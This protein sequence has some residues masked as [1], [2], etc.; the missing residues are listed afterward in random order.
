MKK[1][2]RALKK[3][4]EASELIEQ[5]AWLIGSKSDPSFM[6]GVFIGSRQLAT[7]LLGIDSDLELTGMLRP[8][9]KHEPVEELH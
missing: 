3:V 1:L 7:G 9:N 6:Y 2:A 5:S 8:Q 4:A